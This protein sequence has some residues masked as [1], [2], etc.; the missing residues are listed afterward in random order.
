M[1][2]VSIYK[3]RPPVLQITATVNFTTKTTSVISL[4]YKDVFNQKINF[5]VI[6]VM[7]LY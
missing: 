1:E 7:I 4:S 3:I 2:F 6:C 5:I